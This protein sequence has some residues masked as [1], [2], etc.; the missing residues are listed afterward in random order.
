MSCLNFPTHWPARV[1]AKPARTARLPRVIRLGFLI[2][3]F[4]AVY[5]S[6]VIPL[7]NT[8]RRNCAVAALC[9]ISSKRSSSLSS[10]AFRANSFRLVS[11]SSHLSNLSAIPDTI[12]AKE[13]FAPNKLSNIFPK[14]VLIWF[15]VRACSFSISTSTSFV[16]VL[17][18]LSLNTRRT[19]S[20]L[21][22]AYFFF[23]VFHALLFLNASSAAALPSFVLPS[24]RPF[25]NLDTNLSRVSRSAASARRLFFSS[26][27]FAF[28]DLCSLIFSAL[29]LLL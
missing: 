16:V 3:P 8:S 9:C 24:N 15:C 29:S 6:N 28:S 10:L 17:L 11:D 13:S 1:L 26:R 19:S 22:P 27:R 12:P 14:V 2:W 21:T 18:S 5:S 20:V 23:P 25:V 4:A 7:S